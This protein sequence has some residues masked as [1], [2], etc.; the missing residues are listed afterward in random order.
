MEP[1]PDR[2]GRFRAMKRRIWLVA[3]LGILMASDAV[4]AQQG[5]N[6]SQQGQNCPL[7]VI[8]G[9]DTQTMPD[10]RVTIPVQFEGHDHMLMVDTGGYINT[11]TQ[12]LV[13]EEGYTMEASHGALLR[14]VGNRQLKTYV[15]TNDFAIG[16]AHGKNY[17]FYVD[18]FNNLFADGTLAPEI[19]ANYDVDF[20]F[21]HDKLNLINPDHCPGRVVYWTRSP[22]VVVPMEIESRTHIRIPVT[23]DGKQIMATVDTGSTTSIITMRAAARF[24]G[25][26]E[27]SP[28]LESLGTVRING[29]PGPVYIYPFQA[30]TFGG[31]T[32]KHPYIQIVSDSLW[33]EDDLLLGIDVL[34]QMHL[35]IAYGEKKLYITPALAN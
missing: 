11:V 15:E 30:M 7:H 5:E 19:L 33:N 20:D 22:A 29:V 16:H 13:R 4:L 26:D 17:E 18:T 34:R 8:A 10:G 9:M 24:L 3:L 14:G 23:I 27:R 12:Q 25:V 6:G 31:M 28:G 32:L 2:A 21:G 35:Y 1:G